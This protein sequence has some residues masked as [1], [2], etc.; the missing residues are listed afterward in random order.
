[1]GFKS[2]TRISF[3]LTFCIIASSHPIK[4]FDTVVGSVLLDELIQD[5]ANGAG[6]GTCPRACVRMHVDERVTPHN[7]HG[8]I[9][10]RQSD[11]GHGQGRGDEDKD[12]D[13]DRYIQTHDAHTETNK[14]THNAPRTRGSSALG[15]PDA[16]LD[17]RICD[18]SG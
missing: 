9:R 15:C 5:G 17:L 13:G 14:Q 3:S 10:H 12:V 6:K 1:M 8:K 11:R 2:F 7:K 16:M 4:N 18:M